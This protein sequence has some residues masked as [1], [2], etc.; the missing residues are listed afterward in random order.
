MVSVG[1]KHIILS[2]VRSCNRLGSRTLD[3]NSSNGEG[4]SQ[5]PPTS[6]VS[7]MTEHHPNGRL[8]SSEPPH[9]E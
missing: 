6:T 3:R 9:L 7:A 8:T 1:H 4:G 2:S 5:L